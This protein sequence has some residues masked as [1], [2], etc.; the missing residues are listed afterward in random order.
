MKLTMDM[1]KLFLLSAMW[2]LT[3]VPSVKAQ[4]TVTA[5]RILIRDSVQLGS[6]WIKGVN[7]DGL[8]RYTT[9]HTISTDAALKQYIDNRSGRQA[10]PG[11]YVLCRYENYIFPPYQ[12]SI[13]MD[14]VSADG[15]V[16][17]TTIQ[18]LS[19][20]RVFAAGKT[21][22]TIRG[23]YINKKA[24]TVLGYS[25]INAS[26]REFDLIYYQTDRK[27]YLYDTLRLL[28]EGI[29]SD[30]NVNFVI[31][32]STTS[33]NGRDTLVGMHITFK[34]ITDDYAFEMIGNVVP[35]HSTLSYFNRF[36]MYK[37]GG[38]NFGGFDV[39]GL[40]VM[41]SGG[42]V[43]MNGYRGVFVKTFVNG[44]PYPYPYGYLA[45]SWPPRLY[46][47]LGW[48]E[49]EMELSYMPE[50]EPTPVE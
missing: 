29:L 20:D 45:R 23:E 27:A 38:R 26:G 28:T 36:P 22:F 39:R 48:K 1:N 43:G 9:G 34:N 32:D 35:P 15:I 19:A 3:F 40:Y 5:D 50:E 21:P 17:S 4:N 16:T 11:I 41:K 49:L 7:N 8:L 2:C 33:M 6:H 47:D 37:V 12:D 13:K 46:V 10:G 31:D 42:I 25:V 30:M 44:E 24:G 14:I 18:Q